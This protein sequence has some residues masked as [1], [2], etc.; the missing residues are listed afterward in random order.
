MPGEVSSCVGCHENKNETVATKSTTMALKTGIQS[1]KP[2]Y[3]ITGKGFSFPKVIQPILDAKCVRCHNG[4]EPPDLRAT[5]VWDAAARKFWNQSYHALISKDRP[6]GPANDSRQ[7]FGIIA[8][9][10]KYLNWISRWSVPV[11]I[12]PYSHGSSKSPLIS[13]LKSG[14]EGVRMTRE[15][16][17]KI[18]CW[19][20]LALPHSGDWTEGMTPEDK[21]IYMNVYKRRLEWQKQEALNI[22]EYIDEANAS[23]RPGEPDANRL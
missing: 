19:I 17:D 5:P 10:S 4:S 12:P 15:E 8:E 13:L 7:R 16:M 9:K 21:K 11:M 3:D 18:A 22:Q 6:G 1:L 14:H 2:F 23:N 20:D